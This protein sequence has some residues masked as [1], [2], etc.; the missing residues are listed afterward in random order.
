MKRCTN[1]MIQINSLLPKYDE[2]ERKMNIIYLILKLRLSIN[3]EGHIK[4]NCD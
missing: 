2:Y 4:N 1:F 3:G